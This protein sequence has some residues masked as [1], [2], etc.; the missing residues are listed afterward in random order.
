M[1]YALAK[2][3]IAA[4]KTVIS[5]HM[6]AVPATIIDRRQLLFK[7]NLGSVYPLLVLPRIYGPTLALAGAIEAVYR[8]H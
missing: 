5:M 4:E 3:G 7:M 8:L 6:V 1:E 2:A